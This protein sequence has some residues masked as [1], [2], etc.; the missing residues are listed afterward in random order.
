MSDT[1]QEVKVI[2]FAGLRKYFNPELSVMMNFP[3]SYADL[4]NQMGK[5]NPEAVQVLKNCRIAVDETFVPGTSPIDS[6]K[7]VFL[8]P[9]SS[10]G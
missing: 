4:L 10:G 2:C 7:T 6:T 8:I 9:P 3:S 5:E 1:K